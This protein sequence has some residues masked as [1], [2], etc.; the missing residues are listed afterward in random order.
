M[1]GRDPVRLRPL[2]RRIRPYPD[3]TTASFIRRLAAANFIDPAQIRDLLRRP[4]IPPGPGLAI[5]AGC[6]EQ[7]LILAMPQLG[8]ETEPGPHLAG[9]P[10]RRTQGIAC[11][12]CALA[13]GAGSHVGIY[14][15]HEKVSCP[16]HLLWLGTEVQE[17]GDQ[18]PLQPCPD[19]PAAF[20]R[21]RNLIAR[22]G[23]PAVCRGFAIA[24]I[25]TW[26][27]HDQG[28]QPDSFTARLRALIPAGHRTWARHRTAT[29][30]ALYPCVVGLTAAIASP[31]WA[32]TAHSSRPND[33]LRRIS[34]QAT[35]G[36]IP[37]GQH[38]PLLH[39]MQ[40]GWQPGFPG[41]DTLQPPGPPHIPPPT[42][43]L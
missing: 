12:R 13:R 7:P 43:D 25:I 29:A 3:E 9:R 35:D 1:T 6:G 39:W 19:L 16:R 38:D 10:D 27:W 17:P 14:T 15:T 40:T 37:Q 28:R 34:L 21:H 18:I 33:F 8:A 24:T 26:R 32:Q 22:L 4:G 23:R 11:H 2:P 31:A 30:A 5:L 20:R 41:P 42:R 36:W